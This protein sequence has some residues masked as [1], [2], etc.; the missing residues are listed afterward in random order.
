VTRRQA[1]EA[2]RDE[3]LTVAEFAFIVRQQP[4]AIYQRIA[5][6]QQPGACRVGG[7]L[8]IDFAVACRYIDAVVAAAGPINTVP[9]P[10]G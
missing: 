3:L 9:A 10:K 5:R 6:R 4:K 8:R 2:R 1:L 7:Q